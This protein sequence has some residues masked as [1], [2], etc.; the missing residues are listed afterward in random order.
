M[1]TQLMIPAAGS[2]K[3]LGFSSPKA[4]VELAGDP[5]LVHTLR[6]FAELDLIDDAIV[7][8]PPVER[9]QFE[10]A[11]ARAFGDGGIRI[12]DGGSE[13]QHSVANGLEVLDPSTEIVVIH[14]A[15]RPF[16]DA[17]AI[18]ASIDAAK[19]HGAATVA[20]SCADT[21]LQ[22]DGDA[23]LVDTPDRSRLWA[24]QTPQTFQR[25]VICDAH[26]AAKSDDNVYTDD[27]TMVR[28]MGVSVKIVNGSPNN[29]KITTPEDLAYAEYLIKECLI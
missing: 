24:C 3:R 14:D 4:L 10:D 20:I 27:A 11:I 23:M 16:V 2:G 12:V 17:S 15:A 22:G 28:A 21:I 26:A 1:T 19:I 7:L 6:H 8:V 5:I 18:Q 13:R 29:F 25:D 9:A